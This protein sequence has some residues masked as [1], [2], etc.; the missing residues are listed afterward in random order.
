MVPTCI[1]SAVGSYKLGTAKASEKLTFYLK[2]SA[3]TFQVNQINQNEKDKIL[4]APHLI[5]THKIY[6][7]PASTHSSTDLVIKF[8]K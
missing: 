3:M 1:S 4:L 5:T 7:Q 2:D 8:S 6:P